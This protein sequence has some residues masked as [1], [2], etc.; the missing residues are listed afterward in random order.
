M[1]VNR[2]VNRRASFGSARTCEQDPWKHR[3]D[4]KVTH[5]LPGRR[6]ELNTDNNPAQT[7]LESPVRLPVAFSRVNPP[8]HSHKATEPLRIDYRAF[9]GM[10]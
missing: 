10:V 2:H 1:Y 3:N 4:V 5:G 6:P 9:Y 8:N 7:P